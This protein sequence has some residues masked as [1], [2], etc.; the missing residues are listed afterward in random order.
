M[1]SP[2]ESLTTQ[3]SLDIITQMIQK[4]KGSVRENSIYFLLWGIVTV[5][6]NLGM[7]TLIKLDYERPYLAWLIT[8]P[9][10]LYSM[11]IGFRRGKKQ[12][13]SSHLDRVSAW[14]WISFGITVFTLIVFGAKI[15]YQLNP[16]IL[17]VSAIP[18]LVAG[19]VIKFKPLIF[20]GV[21]FWVFGVIC[22]LVSGPWQYLVGAVAVF[23]GYLIP[24]MMLRNKKEN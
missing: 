19:V 16:V 18:T 3:E 17:I 5:V 10:W 20:G 9:A 21:A 13:V 11:Y 15:N 7:F 1:N 22:F 8:V 23:T 4:A 2:Q 12:R 14:L 6:A 24:G